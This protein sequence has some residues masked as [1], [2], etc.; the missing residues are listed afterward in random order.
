MWSSKGPSEILA[1]AFI[2]GCEFSDSDSGTTVF[3]IATGARLTVEDTNVSEHTAAK[4][5][6][7]DKGGALILPG[8]FYCRRVRL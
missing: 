1:I 3:H 4:D 2:S 6:L 8:K 7:V 5:S